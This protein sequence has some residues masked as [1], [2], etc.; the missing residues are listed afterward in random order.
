MSTDENSLSTCHCC[1][2][3]MKEE[4]Q[5]QH[6]RWPATDV[7]DELSRSQDGGKRQSQSGRSMIEMLVVAALILVIAAIALPSFA[8]MMRTYKLR[9]DARGIAAQL[10]LVRIRAASDFAQGELSFNTSAGTYQLALC[11]APC[12]GTW[13][14]EGGTVYLSAGNSFGY[15]SIA[16][17]AGTQSSISQSTNIIF[18]SRGIPVD[19]TGAPTSN[20]AIYLTDGQGGY[21]AV[22]VDASSRI[23]IWSYGGSSWIQVD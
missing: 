8:N 2:P 16:A 22:T 3:A 21:V 11:P 20:Y 13:T 6:R 1:S 14:N 7:P 12:S 10:A 18:N 17:A 19:T 5:Q 23:R 4:Q 15:G 9:G